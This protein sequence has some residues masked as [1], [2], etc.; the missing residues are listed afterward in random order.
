MVIELL[1]SNCFPVKLDDNVI[2]AQGQAGP[3][4]FWRLAPMAVSEIKQPFN[5]VQE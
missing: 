3:S 1:V 2:S 4:D 5:M